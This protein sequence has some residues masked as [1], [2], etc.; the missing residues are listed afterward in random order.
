MLRCIPVYAVVFTCVYCGGPLVHCGV[1]VLSGAVLGTLA[2]TSPGGRKWW[3]GGGSG[4][5]GDVGGIVGWLWWRWGGGRRM[6]VV[7][8]VACGGQSWGDGDVILWIT[9]LM[10]MLVMM[11]ILPITVIKIII[12]KVHLFLMN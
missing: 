12:L 3:G 6:V 8:S 2:Q 4:G 7:K 5:G 9:M 10:I 1:V 11:F